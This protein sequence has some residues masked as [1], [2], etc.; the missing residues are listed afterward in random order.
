MVFLP[1]TVMEWDGSQLT[2]TGLL[3]ILASMCLHGLY[4]IGGVLRWGFVTG[5]SDHEGHKPIIGALDRS[6][7]AGRKVDCRGMDRCSFHCCRNCFVE[8]SKVQASWTVFNDS[9]ALGIGCGNM[10][11][12]LHRG[13]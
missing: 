10:Y 6:G 8:W 2:R 3:V 4:I 7:V 5:L 9:T 13:G 12:R 11:S 1:W